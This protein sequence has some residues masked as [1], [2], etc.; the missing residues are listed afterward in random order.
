MAQKERLFTPKEICKSAF[1]APG[2]L[3]EAGRTFVN[4]LQLFPHNPIGSLRVLITSVSQAR[5]IAEHL[6]EDTSLGRNRTSFYEIS[7]IDN[8]GDL[9]TIENSLVSVF[10]QIS[11]IGEKEKNIIFDLKPYWRDGK[12]NLFSIFSL[13]SQMTDQNLIN[14]PDQDFPPT[15]DI[16]KF[17]KYVSRSEKPITIGEQFKILFEISN[18]DLIGAFLIGIIGNRLMARHSDTKICEIYYIEDDLLKDFPEIGV[19]DQTEKDLNLEDYILKKWNSKVCR[20][21]RDIEGDKIRSD[22]PGDNYY[23]WTVC[24]GTFLFS[25]AQ[26]IPELQE[27]AIILGK[28]FERGVKHGMKNAKKCLFTPTMTNHNKAILFG[29]ALGLILRDFYLSQD[30]KNISNEEIS[31]LAQKYLVQ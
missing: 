20:F 21:H 27:E 4:C 1:S 11:R 2:A 18:G 13:I 6:G 15:E 16:L 31:L 14:I 22:G 23:F 12:Y 17:I 28:M 26:N 30:M 19:L 3:I 10:I 9:N 7:F 25:I 8:N 29:R 24:A 5:Q